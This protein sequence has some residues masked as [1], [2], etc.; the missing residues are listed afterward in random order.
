MISACLTLATSL[1]EV[2]RLIHPAEPAM[3]AP[4]MIGCLLLAV[5]VAG[6]LALRAKP[7]RKWRE[8]A[9][10]RK[11]DPLDN[12]VLRPM[13]LARL[14]DARPRRPCGRWVAWSGVVARSGQTPF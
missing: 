9:E 5:A 8:R 6:A 12:T 14:K 1:A 13:L 4:V 3:A 11:G 10:K 7:W 2:R